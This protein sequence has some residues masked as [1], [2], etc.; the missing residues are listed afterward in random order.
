MRK[1]ETDG[2]EVSAFFSAHQ[3]HCYFLHSCKPRPWPCTTFSAS[4]RPTAPR[5]TPTH[6]QSV[7]AEISIFC[8]LSFSSILCAFACL[9]SDAWNGRARSQRTSAGRAR[10]SCWPRRLTPP[11]PSFASVSLANSKL[12]Q[13]KESAK[14]ESKEEKRKV[15]PGLPAKTKRWVREMGERDE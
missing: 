12:R 1:G 13:S 8:F 15:K 9:R 14:R 6:F 3:Q 4:R 2:R 11:A 10:A 7:V 5:Y